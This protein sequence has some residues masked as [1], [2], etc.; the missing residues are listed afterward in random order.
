MCDARTSI[1]KCDEGD[2]NA[3]TGGYCRRRCSRIV[4]VELWEEQREANNQPCGR[5]AVGP[6]RGQFG[7]RPISRVRRRKTLHPQLRRGGRGRYLALVAGPQ[8]RKVNELRRQLLPDQ[9]RAGLV[10]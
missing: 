7:P 4:L 3:V 5:T 8:R 1:R 9:A 10:P 6:S 2:Q